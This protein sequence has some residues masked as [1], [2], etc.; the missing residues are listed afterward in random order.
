MNKETLEKAKRLE[1]LISVTEHNISSWENLFRADEIECQS[2]T[3]EDP[4]YLTGKK[5]LMVRE[6]LLS[7]HRANLEKYK[8]EFESL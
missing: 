8:K 5:K 7:E 1:S 6:L 4:I 3:K 2:K